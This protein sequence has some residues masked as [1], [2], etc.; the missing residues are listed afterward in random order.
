MPTNLPVGIP[1]KPGSLS[2]FTG[3]T[4]SRRPKSLNDVTFVLKIGS[5]SA[6]YP[7]LD[8]SFTIPSP[9]INRNFRTYSGPMHSPNDR[10]L[11]KER[12]SSDAELL[13]VEMRLVS[14]VLFYSPTSLFHQP[15]FR[16]SF[17]GIHSAPGLTTFSNGAEKS[18]LTGRYGYHSSS[19]LK[20]HFRCPCLQSTD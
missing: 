7:F 6:R 11:G 20:S 14:Y 8:C 16:Y 3:L 9:Q 18:S 17:S 19:S 5:S 2:G 13:T 12:R 10:D 15:I 4:C 1:G